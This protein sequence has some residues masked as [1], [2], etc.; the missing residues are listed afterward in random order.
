MLSV[1]VFDSEDESS[2]DNFFH[3]FHSTVHASQ[4]DYGEQYEVVRETSRSILDASFSVICSC[5]RK[6]K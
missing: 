4:N 2:P 1:A 3:V 5:A 6:D